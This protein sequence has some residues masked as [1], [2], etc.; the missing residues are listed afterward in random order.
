MDTKYRDKFTLSGD[1]KLTLEYSTDCLYIDGR[2]F[3]HPNPSGNKTRL[4]RPL[5]PVTIR[6]GK[7]N[8]FP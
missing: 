4:I 1:D 6:F 7:N 5:G 2:L 3:Q 8:I